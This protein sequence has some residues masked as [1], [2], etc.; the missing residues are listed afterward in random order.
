[1]IKKTLTSV[2]IGDA[3]GSAVDGMTRGH[4]HSH[5]KT[6][7]G[8]IDPEPALKNKLELWRKP[9]LYSSMAQMMIIMAMACPRRGPCA[10]AFRSAIAS[11]PEVAGCDFGIFRYPGAVER[12]FIQRMKDQARHPQT[13]EQPCAR[14]I[15]I[16]TFLSFRNNSTLDHLI[17]TMTAVRL[18]THDLSTI[19]AAL[20][21][22]S[23]LR[24]AASGGKAQSGPIEASIDAA[25]AVADAI[26]S[27]SAAIFDASINPGTLIREVR[28]YINLLND[29]ASAENLASAEKIIIS[30]V[31]AS[32]K[33]PVTRAT[34][35]LPLVLFPYALA[36]ASLA[37]PGT[38]PLLSAV[39]EGG[40]TAALAAM[41]GAVWSCG[42]DAPQQTDCL[43]MNLVNR[44]KVLALI[45]ALCGGAVAPEVMDDFIRSEASLTAKEQEE[46]GAKL[47]HVK[48][49]LKKPPTTRAE[50]E[51]ELARHAVE[52]WT[53]YDKARWKKER[54]RHDKNDES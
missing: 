50:K 22:T 41:A 6:I 13:P 45:D 31:N 2:L 25:A 49:K 52:S 35:N 29:I 39:S 23:L 48:K 46:L 28:A 17:D 38:A 5:F 36:L 11:S 1:M 40:S 15:P 33:T 20:I 4:I 53:K 54:R 3:L 9:G 7:T 34:V 37:P 24:T 43:V 14:I 30:Q 18:F 32:L 44:R 42:N 51:K 10:E 27:N 47:K 8:Y 19:A 16:M 26:E 21:Y 12:S